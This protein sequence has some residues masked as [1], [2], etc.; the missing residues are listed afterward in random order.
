MAKGFTEFFGWSLFALANLA[1]I[2]HHVVLVGG[3]VD[4]DRTEGEVLGKLGLGIVFGCRRAYAFHEKGDSL[5]LLTPERN[6][7]LM[8]PP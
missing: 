7:K 6:A 2:D 1:A 4:T 8:R 3:P 5:W